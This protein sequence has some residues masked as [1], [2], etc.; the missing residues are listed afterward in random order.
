MRGDHTQRPRTR[1]A[2]LEGLVAG[3]GVAERGSAGDTLVRA[4]GPINPL[5]GPYWTRTGNGP[6]AGGRGTEP[7]RETYGMGGVGPAPAE[8]TGSGMGSGSRIGPK[9]VWGRG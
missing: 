2:V 9:T 5:Q 7:E 4:D 8:N 3:V 1:E 6:T